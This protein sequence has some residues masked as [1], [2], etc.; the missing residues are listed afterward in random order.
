MI[1]TCQVNLTRETF[2]YSLVEIVTEFALTK[3]EA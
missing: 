3:A 1:K 2:K